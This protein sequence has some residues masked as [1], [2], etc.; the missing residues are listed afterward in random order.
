MRE[1]MHAAVMSSTPQSVPANRMGLRLLIATT[2]ALNLASAG[3]SSQDPVS[4]IL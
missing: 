2:T 1:L 4:E 3:Q